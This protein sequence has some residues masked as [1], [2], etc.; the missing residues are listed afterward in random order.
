MS[1]RRRR[2]VWAFVALGVL[3]VLFVGLFALNGLVLA[4]RQAPRMRHFAP[5]S[6]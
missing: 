1:R 3:A 4:D 5:A 2:V 6:P